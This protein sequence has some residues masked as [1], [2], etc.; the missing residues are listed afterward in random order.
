[1]SPPH[2]GGDKGEVK[3]CFKKNASYESD[4]SYEINDSTTHP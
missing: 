1:M 4:Y 2:R 3:V